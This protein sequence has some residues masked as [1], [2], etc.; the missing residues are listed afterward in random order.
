[1]NH[2]RTFV[3]TA[4]LVSSIIL[5]T[6]S[7][8]FAHVTVKPTQTTPATYQVFSVAVPNEKNIPTIQV[9]LLIP[10]NVE[11]VTPNIKAGW[12]TKT[13]TTNDGKVTE[14]IW[15]KGAIPEGFRDEFVFSAKTGTTE[16]SIIWKAYQT[17]S[18]GTVVVWDADPH[19]EDSNSQASE[20][21]STSGP[22]SETKVTTSSTSTSDDS[23]FAIS[24]LAVLVSLYSLY[25]ATKTRKAARV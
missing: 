5:G 2:A 10:E 11:S 17:Y 12:V 24:L 20:E 23:L 22:Y 9:R 4:L 18:D 14:I 16:E 15:S 19:E 25:I 21:E 13:V 1:M 6:T 8:A 7:Y 3:S